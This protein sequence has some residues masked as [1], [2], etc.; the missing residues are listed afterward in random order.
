MDLD[1][2]GFIAYCDVFQFEHRV[3]FFRFLKSYDYVENILWK[4]NSQR[5]WGGLFSV[6]HIQISNCWKL[7]GLWV[8]VSLAYGKDL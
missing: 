1:I 4:C 5:P 2:I 8:L 6:D 3:V 7:S